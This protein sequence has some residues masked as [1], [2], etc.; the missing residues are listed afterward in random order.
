VGNASGSG[1]QPQNRLWLRADAGTSTT[2]NG[3]PVSAWNDQSGNGNNAAQ[4]TSDNQPLF[5]ASEPLANN[6]PVLR[7]DGIDD[8][9]QTETHITD[10]VGTLMIVARKTA[11]GV[12]AYRTIFTSQ[13]FLMLGRTPS[14]D[15]WGRTM[16]V[17]T[18]YTRRGHLLAQMLGRR[19]GYWGIG[20]M[21]REQIN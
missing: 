5:I 19:F 18:G 9:M 4:G 12:G 6:R 11:A 13:D 21:G 2:T 10:N 15:V 20:R 3:Q 8:W 17:R 1:G 14:Q 16:M 7:F